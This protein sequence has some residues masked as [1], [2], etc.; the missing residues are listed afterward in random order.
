M[1]EYI[2]YKNSSI[3]KSKNQKSKYNKTISSNSNM[4]I[5]NK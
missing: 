2:K 4:K 1:S 3:N 5:K